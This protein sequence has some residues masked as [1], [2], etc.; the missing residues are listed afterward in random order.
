MHS[1]AVARYTATMIQPA[2]LTPASVSHSQA[3]ETERQHR[4]V[5]EVEGIAEARTELDAG[6]HLHIADLRAWVDSLRT[7]TPL[8][9]PPIRPA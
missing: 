7:H 1:R 9:L 5:W 2:P 8:P 6:R 4:L 3:T